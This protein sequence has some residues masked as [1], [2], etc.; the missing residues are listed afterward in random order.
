[1]KLKKV[2]LVFCVFVGALVLCFLGIA[3]Y[4]EVSC[5]FAK[6]VTE[7][8]A[9][10]NAREEVRKFCE[11][12]YHKCDPS[13]YFVSARK[14]GKDPADP[15]HGAAWDFQFSDSAGAPRNVVGVVVDRKGNPDLAGF[16]TLQTPASEE[17]SYDTG[18]R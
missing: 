17:R 9:E 5:Y 10:K 15:R 11:G 14:H 8:E 18:I 12:K 16:N 3:V 2:L 1:M 7:A 4:N 13:K 6:D